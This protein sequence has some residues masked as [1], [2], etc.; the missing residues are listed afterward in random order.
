MRVTLPYPP[1]ANLYWRVW[2]GRPVKSTE[3]RR[4]Q[5]EARRSATSQGMRPLSGDVSVSL[6]V[7]RPRRIGDLDNAQKVLLDALKGVAYEDDRQVTEIHAIRLD[8]KERPRVE[9]VVRPVP[10]PPRC[11][12]CDDVSCRCG[13]VVR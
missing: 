12:G 11:G 7:Y 4:Y 9:V 5:E 1:T 8:D 6:R 10:T 2:R 3:A 13:G